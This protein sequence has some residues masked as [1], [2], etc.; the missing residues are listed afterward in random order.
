[1]KR[2]V[3]IGLIGSHPLPTKSPKRCEEYNLLTS[4]KELSMSWSAI[5]E[6]PRHFACFVSL[7]VARFD[8]RFVFNRHQN[9]YQLAVSVTLNLPS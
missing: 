7:H 6:L 8:A 4:I 5:L 3:T 2:R 1:M 9:G